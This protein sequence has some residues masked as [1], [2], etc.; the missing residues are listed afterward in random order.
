MLFIYNPASIFFHSVYTESIY[1]SVTLL[2]MHFSLKEEFSK[3]NII[4]T[5]LLMLGM[6]FRSN[7]MFLAPIV[8][9][10]ILLRFFKAI[11]ERKYFKILKI[12][13][14]GSFILF[15]MLIPFF[16]HLYFSFSKICFNNL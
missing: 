5:A 9:F 8:G 15:F 6:N 4:L 1:M 14:E 2:F 13:L 7:C 12:G 10:P 16:Y 3:K 11:K